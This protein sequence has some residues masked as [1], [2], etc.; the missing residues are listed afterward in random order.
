MAPPKAVRIDVVGAPPGTHLKVD[1]VPS[2]IP[3]LLPRGPSTYRLLFEATGYES[4]EI[5]VDGSS[6]RIIT[7]TMN[8]LRASRSARPS[9]PAGA[10]TSAEKASK[11]KVTPSSR[12]QRKLII[13]E[14]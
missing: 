8:K 14:L 10:R 4:R 3:A 11:P 2:A 1:G 9:W 13:E 7:L 12:D 6:D 5:Q